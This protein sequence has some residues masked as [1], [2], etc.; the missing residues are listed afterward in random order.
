MLGNRLAFGTRQ[1]SPTAPLAQHGAMPQ[2][3]SEHRKSKP[4]D[5]N[6][7]QVDARFFDIPEIDF[8]DTGFGHL[9]FEVRCKPVLEGSTI[10]QVVV[11]AIVGRQ[12]REHPRFFDVAFPHQG[13]TNE[14]DLRLGRLLLLGQIRFHRQ[15]V[16]ESGRHEFIPRLFDEGGEFFFRGPVSIEGHADVKRW[17]KASSW[18]SSGTIILSATTLPRLT[19]RAL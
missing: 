4:Q 12:A 10:R 5:V 19:S 11:Q 8:G 18:A 3:A 17:T 13:L 1:R 14:V 15:Q 7:P 9:L 16:A 6:T 2:D